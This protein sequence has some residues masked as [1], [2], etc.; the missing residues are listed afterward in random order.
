MRFGTM[1][2]ETKRII[3]SIKRSAFSEEE[4]TR[5]AEKLIK[6]E[7]TIRPP[8][9]QETGMYTREY[10]VIYGHFEYYVAVRAMELDEDRGD[11]TSVFLLTPTDKA[12][13]KEAAIL[14][15][16]KLFAEKESGEEIHVI[17]D[18]GENHPEPSQSVDISLLLKKVEVLEKTLE[19]K[20]ANLENTFNRKFDQQEVQIQQILEYVKP[21]K[22]IA[23]KKSISPED[24]QAFLDFLNNEQS[25]LRDIDRIGP[26]YEKSIVKYRPY[27]SLDDLNSKLEGK[28]KGFSPKKTEYWLQNFSLLKS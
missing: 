21:K 25:N 16:V 7:G 14:E 20:T 5:F 22:K 2:V 18:S 26:A 10:E 1:F 24:V 9:V 12:P 6:L 23:E 17:Q 13:E 15:L 4:L 3:S 27:D 28:V 11:M 19:Q 8:V